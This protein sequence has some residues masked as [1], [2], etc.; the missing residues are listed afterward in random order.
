MD[1]SELKSELHR[2]VEMVNDEEMLYQVRSILSEHSVPVHDWADDLSDNLRE[3][4]EAS[5]AESE[6]GNGIDHE[7]AMKLINARYGKR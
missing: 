3:A 4:L 2:L 1:Y 6:K 7:E 5:I